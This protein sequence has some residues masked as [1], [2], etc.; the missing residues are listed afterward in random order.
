MAEKSLKAVEFDADML[1]A[2][3]Q[4]VKPERVTY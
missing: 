1:R 2:E 4:K 3:L